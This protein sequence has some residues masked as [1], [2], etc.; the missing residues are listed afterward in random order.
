MRL[1]IFKRLMLGYGA[2]LILLMGLGIYVAAQLNRLNQ[3]TW[4]VVM[5]D[6]ETV[7]L[8]ETLDSLAV[9]LTRFEKKHLIT[10]DSAF[11]QRFQDLRAEFLQTH[12]TI[13]RH[14]DT[15]EPQTILD[16]IGTDSAAYFALIDQERERLQGEGG[17]PADIYPERKAELV[18][19]IR[20]ALQAIMG[21][22]REARDRKILESSRISVE[23]IR[24]GIVT[25]GIGGAV[26]L[27]ISFV[28]ARQIR[29][30]IHRLQHKTH[31]VALGRFGTLPA[32]ESPPEIAALTRDFNRMCARLEELNAM[33]EDFIYHVS[34]ELRTPLTAI[35]EASSML[36]EGF[37]NSRIE[38]Q[39]QLLAIV[40]SECERLIQ[41]IN[42]M[43]DLSRMEAQMMAYRFQPVDLAALVR[44]TILRL[45]P[46]A[47]ARAIRLEFKPGDELPAAKG[48]PARLRQLLDNLLGNALK[49]TE[50]GG[51]VWVALQLEPA[52]EG[53]LRVEIHDTGCGIPQEALKTIFDKFHRI[54]RGQ[55]TERGTGLGLSIAKHIVAAHGGTIWATSQPGEGSVF[56]F[57]LPVT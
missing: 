30:S 35:R 51:Q 42:R 14:I 53:L 47:V 50:A 10:G 31:E 49:Y 1:T 40:S 26:G 4:A 2:F 17:R 57:T 45:A 23:V 54:D 5:Q 32:V 19:N 11:F 43:L 15:G 7:R 20:L 44:D 8:A 16:A 28:S 25:I 22:A 34:H 6:G 56:A 52:S 36:R 55:E 24:I 12:R 33:K 9:S 27:L 29:R 38:D 18:D 48:D 13:D 3:L 21:Q 37:F 46:L 39:T 41:S